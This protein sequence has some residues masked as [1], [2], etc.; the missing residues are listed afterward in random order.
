MH[1][2][3]TGRVNTVNTPK[4]NEYCAAGLNLHQI[5]WNLVGI[6]TWYTLAYMHRDTRHNP[7]DTCIQLHAS[8]ARCQMQTRQW[9]ARFTTGE[10]KVHQICLRAVSWMLS[11]WYMPHNPLV[12]KQ[13]SEC[14]WLENNCTGALPL[15]S[16]RSS[17]CSTVRWS[18]SNRT[19]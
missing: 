18:N 9:Y 10:W 11:S 15:W 6:C 2:Q 14:Q 13:C 17:T 16:R 4:I 5:S 19:H 8:F 7:L 3:A 12:E 1:I